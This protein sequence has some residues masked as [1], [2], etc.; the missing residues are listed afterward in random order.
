[1]K[2]ICVDNFDSGMVSDKLV[3][4]NTTPF[5]AN[6]IVVA[7]NEKFCSNHSLDYFRAVKDDYE[8]YIYDPR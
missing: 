8:L 1:M 6:L 2:V 3:C 7:L 5:Y 4:E